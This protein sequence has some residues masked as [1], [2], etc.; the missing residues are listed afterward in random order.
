MTI[1]RKINM[2][3]NQYKNW[4]LFGK[5]MFWSFKKAIGGYVFCRD[6]GKYLQDEIQSMKIMGIGINEQNYKDYQI[7]KKQL[8]IVD[9][10]SN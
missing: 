10:N 9:D 5:K 2:I 4:R 7:A 3:Y 1:F 6:L 8:G